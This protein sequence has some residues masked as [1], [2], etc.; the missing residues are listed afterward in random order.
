VKHLIL[1]RHAE[2]NSQRLGQSDF[3]RPLSASGER[4][5]RA[6]AEMLRC[7]GRI[8]DLMVCS[9]AVRTTATARI[10]ADTLNLPDTIVAPDRHLYGA[11]AH[12]LLYTIAG[13]PE[14]CPC[15][16]LVGHNPAISDLACL[17]V[18]TPLPSMR[19][20]EAVCIRFAEDCWKKA[21]RSHG[22]ITRITD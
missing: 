16:A 10:I 17:L 19:T 21:A 7:D 14:D 1:I 4:E 15:I 5:A 20:G 11:P 12:A 13:F 2:S 6:T 3:D 8:P 18:E 9:A 22:A